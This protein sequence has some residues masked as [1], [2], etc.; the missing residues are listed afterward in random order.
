MISHQSPYIL[1]IFTAITLRISI[2]RVK[3]RK[4]IFLMEIW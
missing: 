3:F 2:I 4:I 1:H